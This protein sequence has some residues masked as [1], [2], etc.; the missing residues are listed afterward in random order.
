MKSKTRKAAGKAS[1]DPLVRSLTALALTYRRR[2]LLT[3][4]HNVYASA[5]WRTAS[6]DIIRALDANSS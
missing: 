5:I 3:R 6:E 2:Q 1:L 4:K